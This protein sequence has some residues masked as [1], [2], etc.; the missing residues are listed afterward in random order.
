MKKNLENLRRRYLS[1]FAKCLLIGVLLFPQISA[2]AQERKISGTVTGA[3]NEPIIGATVTV[4]GT[5][6]GA[7]TDLEG[8]FTLSI[9]S[10]AKT[11]MVSFVGFDPKSVEIGASNF[12]S[13][14]LAE[15][16]VGL[17]EVVVIGYGTQK[18]IT[19]TGAVVSVESD[20]L[21]KS[22]TAVVSQALAGRVTGLTTVQYSGQPGRD[23]PNIFVRGVGSLSTSNSAPLT[24]VDGV[25][26]SFTQLDPNEIE[27]I[28]VLKDASATAVYGIRGANG[29]IIVTTRR[30]AE[31]APKISYTSSFGL[32]APTRLVESVD[33]YTYAIKHNEAKLNDDPNA[34]LKF[35]P[36]VVEAFRTG[37]Y[38]LIFPNTNW[39]D[40]LVKKVSPQSQ[41]NINITGG[42]KVVKYF[43]SLGAFSQNGLYETFDD[44]YSYTYGFKRYNVRA[45]IDVDMTESTKFS[46]TVGHRSELRQEPGNPS[47]DGAFNVLY[48]AVPYSGLLQDG[49]RILIGNRYIAS[50]EA[51][52]KDGLNAIGWG[53][54]FRKYLTNVINLDLG[55][56][57]KLNFITKGLEWR[58]KMSNNSTIGYEK[59]RTTSFPSY[60]PFFKCDVDASA[61]GDSTIVFRKSG[62]YGLLGYSEAS[63]K[64]RNWYVETALSYNRDFGY[65]NVTGLLLYNESKIFYPSNLSD[66]PTGYVGLA[67]RA[68]YNYKRKY[69]FD[70]NL[71]YNGSEN[72]APGKRFGLFPAYAVGWVLSEE[73]F[74]KN[75]PTSIISY[76]KFRASYGVVGNDRIGGSRFLYLADSYSINDG[77]GYSFGTSTDVLQLTAAEG[78]IGNPGVTWE[79][80]TKQNYGVDLKFF[81]GK[82]GLTT[83]YFS[84]LRNNILTTRNTV[85]LIVS[86]SLPA[87]NIGKVQNHG[88]EVEVKWRDRIG[89]NVNYWLT[90]NLS[91]A[92]NKILYMDEVPKNV[93][94]RT[95]TGQSVDARFAYV[96]D[97]FWTSADTSHLEEFPNHSYM[98]KPGDVRYKDLDG[99]M[100]INDDD[101]RIV[102]YPDYPE[103]NYSISGG[104]DYK[105]FDISFLWN[106]VAN[107]SREISGLWKIAF[108]N[109]GDRGLTKWLA[110]NAW[111]P[112][113]AETAIAPRMT[114]TGWNN[115]TKT[116]DLWIRNASYL[117]LKN[118]ELGYRLSPAVLK[119]LGISSL[120]LSMSGYDLLTFDKMK[121]V[122]PEARTSSP[123]YPLVKIYNFGVQ[124]NF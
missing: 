40:I 86:M 95:Q 60:D 35:S 32:Q 36:F 89:Q 41:H 37:E 69:M 74:F 13:I 68:T 22:P 65:H 114:F 64:S 91:F 49:K 38:P 103:Y 118:L 70:F 34:A 58:A 67:G 43:V 9:P 21:V 88:F 92:K 48:W 31:G 104:F 1:L 63:S 106:G 30:G 53:T 83:D 79:K 17:E 24:L 76:V 108:G 115:N 6:L 119:R 23:E 29:V 77:T 85:P 111:T 27:S 66:I 123:D 120:R 44:T 78:R 113:T 116:S 71:G 93:P 47:S 28:S 72:F 33:S 84:E 51:S 50:T 110:E 55:V 98:P 56:T 52:N 12:Y 124:V 15:S 102:G 100:I 16:V 19:V 59:T 20:F 109:L 82:F 57:Q 39:A 121:F 87:V 14:V 3:N 62:S 11:L 26:R 122:D 25:E 8:N 112:E 5:T 94:W 18:R 107:V 61:P 80:A 4:Q 42:S 81:N 105:G 117:R 101:Q 75:V 99:N 54:G 2:F 7:L 73:N 46:L 97:G 96:F 90:T 10:T 45:N